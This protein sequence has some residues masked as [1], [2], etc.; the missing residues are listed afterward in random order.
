VADTLRQR[1]H[2]ALAAALGRCTACDTLADRCIWGPF[3]TAG[4]LNRLVDAALDVRDTELE[5]AQHD[6]LTATVEAV[7]A[8]AQAAEQLAA[9][10]ARADQAEAAN[11][12]ARARLDELIE[13]GFG[14]V[15]RTL[16]EL[17]AILGREP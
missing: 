13:M 5:T 4:A 16:R 10:Q 12:R 15:G 6:V 1:L 8:E 14:A 9:A 17:R 2:D 3:G 11:A 7:H